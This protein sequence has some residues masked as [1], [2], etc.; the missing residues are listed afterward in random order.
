M[1]IDANLVMGLE[2]GFGVGLLVGLGLAVA[3]VC[4][5]RR[6]VSVPW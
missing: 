6:T 5:C 2:W 3:V 4:T 1:T